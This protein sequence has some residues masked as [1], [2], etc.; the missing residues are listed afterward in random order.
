M[1]NGVAG[2]VGVG[3]VGAV[4]G[5]EQPDPEFVGRGISFCGSR[6]DNLCRSIHSIC[7]ASRSQP[8]ATSSKPLFMDRF[9]AC[10]ARPLAS[11][12]FFRYTSAGSDIRSERQVAER[13]AAIAQAT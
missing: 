12:A 11:A 3:A 4:G 8:F 9:F 6:L 1:R 7:S 5:G 2:A 10:A 13:R